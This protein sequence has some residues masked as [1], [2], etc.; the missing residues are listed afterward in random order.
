[1]GGLSCACSQRFTATPHLPPIPPGWNGVASEELGHSPAE[2]EFDD[3]KANHTRPENECPVPQSGLRTSDRPNTAGER[4]D[5]RGSEQVCYGCARSNWNS[6]SFSKASR[7]VYS[8]DLP[9]E[10][11]LPVP[12]STEPADSTG[13]EWISY[14]ALASPVG[15]DA[16]ANLHDNPGEFMPHHKW[17]LAQFVL[18]EKRRDFGAA[19]PGRFHVENNPAG[20]RV[21]F[22]RLIRTHPSN[23]LPDLDLQ[24]LI[25]L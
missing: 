6:G 22:R 13:D 4:L 20:L 3:R 25:R 12:A 1:R 23:R 16:I 11:Q 19:Y 21:W 10:A 24:D 18:S 2:K 8:Y 15:R 7:I 5:Q 9:L 17:R 14:N